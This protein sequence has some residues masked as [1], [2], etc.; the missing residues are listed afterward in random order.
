MLRRSTNVKV[1]VQHRNAKVS[2]RLFASNKA[3]CFKLSTWE[4][5]RDGRPGSDAYAFVEFADHVTASA[6]LTT[7]NQRLFL[8]KMLY[9]SMAKDKYASLVKFI[10]LQLINTID[11]ARFLASLRIKFLQTSPATWL[12]GIRK[13]VIPIHKVFPKWFFITLDV[14]Y[15]S[16]NPQNE[17][18]EKAEYIGRMNFQKHVLLQNIGRY[19]SYEYRREAD[20]SRRNGNQLGVPS[21]D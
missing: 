17:K 1:F 4:K 21:Y 19:V 11:L 3:I 18:V 6:A 16:S 15:T 8:E 2:V 12:K 10:E 14:Q 13:H 5:S 9:W 20:T 7:L